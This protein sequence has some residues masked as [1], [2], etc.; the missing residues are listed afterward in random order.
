MPVRVATYQDVQGAID[1]GK[2]IL[3]RSSINAEVNDLDAKRA[4]LR[5]INDANMN[6]WVAEHDNKIVGFLMVIK[7]C[8]WFGRDKYASD[9]CFVVE[10]HHGNYAPTMIK[11]FIKWAKSDP[12]VKDISLAI[13]SGLD[14]DERTGRMYQNLGFTPVGGVYTILSK[15]DVCPV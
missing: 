14:K 6:L 13:S 7:E 2:K 1:V 5:S 9:L 10:S 12:K 4:M 15:E 11:R 8:H 3:A